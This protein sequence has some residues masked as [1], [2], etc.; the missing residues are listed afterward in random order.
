[1]SRDDILKQFTLGAHG[2]KS[3]CEFMEKVH[4][5]HDHRDHVVSSK[6]E[7]CDYCAD[8]WTTRDANTRKKCARSCTQSFYGKL[9]SDHT[10]L[11]SILFIPPIRPTYCN[12]NQI[13]I[14]YIVYRVRYRVLSVRYR[15]L[16]VRYRVLSVR[17][18]YL[19]ADS[20]QIYKTNK[21]YC[22]KIDIE[23]C[24]RSSIGDVT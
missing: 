23:K 10:R 5:S 18:Q 17:C 16:R 7:V 19:S 21:K 9:C 6:H 11:G 1:M 22:N 3:R 4:N 2:P 8:L 14:R 13:C 20:T 24:P 12:N 15:V